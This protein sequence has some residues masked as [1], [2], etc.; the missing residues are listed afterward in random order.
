MTEPDAQSLAPIEYRYTGVKVDGV[1]YAQRL[2]TVIA[3][4][5][6]QA[7]P[8][9]YRSEVW[10]EMFL[11]GSLDAVAGAPHRVRVNRDH[12]KSRTV[13]KAVQLWPDRPE[14]LVAE[15]RIAKTPLGDETLALAEEDC[16]SS[17]V[18][19]GVMP[20][21]QELDRRSMT[22]RI[23]KAYLDH[24]AFVESPAYVG[25]QVLSVRDTDGGGAAAVLEPI[26]TPLI[27]EF[28]NDEILRWASQRLNKQ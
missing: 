21:D 15:I 26:R 17:S 18:G 3:V 16:L 4:P 10:N 25:A 20:Q 27:D 22:R 9:E 13:G 11:R 24:I 6:E 8:V 19:F 28:T 2:I 7:T 5:Y 14:G 1:D 12:N 23:R